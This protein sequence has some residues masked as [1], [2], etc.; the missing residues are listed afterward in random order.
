M[1]NAKGESQMIGENGPSSSSLLNDGRADVVRLGGGFPTARAAVMVGIRQ[2]L[3]LREYCVEFSTRGVFG[4]FNKKSALLTSIIILCW[5]IHNF[6]CPRFAIG[7]IWS[8][9][10]PSQ[11]SG[12]VISFCNT[13]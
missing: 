10:S 8:H 2:S 13:V 7:C 4:S 9:S 3:F 12:G 6:S 5:D 11:V 1:V